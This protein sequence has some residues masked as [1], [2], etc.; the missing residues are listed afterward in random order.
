MVFD[1][2]QSGHN[3]TWTNIWEFLQLLLIQLGYKL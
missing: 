3:Q 2:P 1:R